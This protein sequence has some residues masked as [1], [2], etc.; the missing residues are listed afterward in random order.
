MHAIALS[1]A[2]MFFCLFA[3][4]DEYGSGLYI[5]LAVLLTGIVCTSRLV[6]S[7]HT[8]FEVWAGI[9]VGLLSQYVGWIWNL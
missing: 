2:T 8:S 5:A 7:S 9:F 6:L 1:G 4:N 3:F